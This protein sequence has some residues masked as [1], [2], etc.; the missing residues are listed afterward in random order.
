MFRAVVALILMAVSLPLW[1]DAGAP[2]FRLEYS[3]SGAQ[4]CPSDTALQDAVTA[5]L[6]YSPWSTGGA[7]TLVVVVERGA[8]GFAGSVTLLDAD[9]VTL[10]R[11][12]LTSRQAT[13]DG[14]ADALALAMAIAIDP[15]R[16]MTSEIQPPPPEPP[17]Q[18]VAPPEPPAVF[19]DWLPSGSPTPPPE[20]PPPPEPPPTPPPAPASTPSAVTT[21]PA[22]TLPPLRV[23]W[24][25]RSVPS[26]R[27]GYFVGT[28]A[29]LALWAAPAP[30]PGAWLFA[31]VMVESFSLAV[32]VRLDV[33]TF[34][35][36]DTGTVSVQ[37]ALVQGA[38]CWHPG[39]LMGCVTL[40][41]GGAQAA[42]HGLDRAARVVLPVM[43]AG[44]RA[45]VNAPLTR[46]MAVQ[47]TVDA[48]AVPL[49]IRLRDSVSGQT[50]WSTP[51]L[52]LVVGAAV[53]LRRP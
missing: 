42:G 16:A 36:V 50:L 15:L 23:R 37:H 20:T 30:A 51:P 14:L 8:E 3:R 40:G 32:E 43:T 6:G 38:G 5:R 33:P 21:P 1:A 4:Q 53:V 17:P 7:R 29:R 48:V 9:R 18:L 13:C 44:V 35:V 2:G 11:R 45:G 31:G 10:G 41:G 47:F 52:G 39:V 24:P 27:L 34:S 25:V 26:W 49:G 46:L 19:F 12:E 28:G 22:P